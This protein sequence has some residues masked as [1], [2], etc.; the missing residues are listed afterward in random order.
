MAYANYQERPWPFATTYV[1]D[2][3]R[4]RHLCWNLVGSD[5]RSRFRRSR[6]G[7]LWAIIQPLAFSL[8]LALVWGT[9]FKTKTFWEFAVYTYS[10]LI[11]WDFLTTGGIA[12]GLHALINS[13]G[14]L[15][16]SKIPL[17]VF[18]AR[19][20][21]T[22]AVMF[23]F[24]LVGLLGLMAALQMLPPFGLHYLLVLAFIPMMLCMATPL[25]I[26]FSLVGAQFRDSQHI[27][28]LLIQGLFFV[29]PVMLD[30]AVLHQPQLAWLEM[31][32][33]AISMLDL[34]RDPLLYGK[35]WNV[36]T[37]IT[38]WSWVAVFWVLALFASIRFGRRI[39]FAL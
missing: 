37:L 7:I 33:P 2:L 3:F 28:G 39:V 5:L 11:A 16:Q 19:I 14:Y 38:F 36:H 22:S 10:G 4:F 34:F 27:V 25:S 1:L 15:K 35:L 30:R 21:L 9:V 17:L 20:P 24:A 18:Q 13:Q 31:L 29:S 12:G 32:N 23:I 8:M 26:L 6:I